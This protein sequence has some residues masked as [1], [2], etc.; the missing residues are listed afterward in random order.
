[1]LGNGGT[2]VFWDVATFGLVEARS[3][4]LVF[5]E[6][7]SKF[8][9][10]CAAAPHLEAPVIVASEPATTRTPCRTPPSTSTH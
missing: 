8:A 10:A 5:G 1:M 9:T 6:F 4:H 7:S 3:E 2:T